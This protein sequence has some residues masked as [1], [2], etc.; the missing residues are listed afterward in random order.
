MYILENLNYY[1]KIDILKSYIHIAMSEK[2]IIMLRGVVS[3]CK[4]SVFGLDF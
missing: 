1:D 2:Q 4:S 3:R